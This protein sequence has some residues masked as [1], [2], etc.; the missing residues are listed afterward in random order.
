MNIRKTAGKILKKY[1]HAW[2]FLYA[3]IYMPWFTWLEKRTGV[4]YTMVH[5]PLDSY[6]PFIEYF[7]IP[8]LL[9]FVFIATTGLYFFFTEKQS[10]YR[11][12]AFTIT[13]MTLFLIIC[14][15]LS[16]RTGAAVLIHF[17]HDNIFVSLCRLSMLG[18]GGRIHRPMSFPA[19]TYLTRWEPLWQSRTALAMKKPPWSAT[20]LIVWRH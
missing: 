18:G 14:T 3:L 7:V 10:F 15:F 9:W 13:G 1:S 6:I 4:Q 2:V 19:F 5:S 16:E 11:M 17:E 12:A 20:A 8:Y